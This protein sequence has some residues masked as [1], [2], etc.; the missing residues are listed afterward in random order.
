MYYQ[1]VIF[2]IISAIYYAKFQFIFIYIGQ[3]VD[4]ILPSGF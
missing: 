1:A 4:T 3:T 2:K